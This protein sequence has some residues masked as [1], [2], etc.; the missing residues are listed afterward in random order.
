MIEKKERESKEKEREK[1]EQLELLGDIQQR[2]RDTIRD[3]KMTIETL[4]NERDVLL[5]EKEEQEQR[6]A[7]LEGIQEQMKEAY[8]RSEQELRNAFN[9]K[10]KQL[11]QSQQEKEEKEKPQEKEAI[12]YQNNI[13]TPEKAEEII[14]ENKATIKELIAQKNQS[15]EQNKWDALSAGKSSVVKKSS[16]S[17][18][19]KVSV[20]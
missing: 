19:K 3:L 6:F 10:L 11:E 15:K 18:S 9:Q 12:E 4:K 20:K 7:F 5:K 17:A 16:K 14:A 2:Y 13:V 8:E 1:N